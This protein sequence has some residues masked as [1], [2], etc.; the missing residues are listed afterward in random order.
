MDLLAFVIYG[1]GIAVGIG[2]AV[3]RGS[4]ADAL[5]AGLAAVGGSLIAWHVLDTI[6]DRVETHYE[7]KLKPKSKPDS[8]NSAL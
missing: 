2:V 6:R 3:L 5:V 8:T 7:N 4:I 1:I